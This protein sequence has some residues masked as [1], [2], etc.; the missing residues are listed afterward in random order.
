[1]PGRIV[2][3]TTPDGSATLVERGRIH[4]SGNWNFGSGGVNLAHVGIVNDTA[5]DVGL[6]VRMAAAQSARWMRVEDS[7]GNERFALTPTAL[8]SR[9][10]ATDNAW[11]AQ[12]DA[13]SFA[14]FVT[15][16]DGLL[17]WGGGAG[18][19]ETNL[20]REAA[21]I[22][23]TDDKLHVVGEIEVDGALNHDGTTVGFYAKVPVVQPTIVKLTDN[24]GGTGDDTIAAASML[25]D[26]SSENNFRADVARK[27]N[28]ILDAAGQ[29]AS[30]TGLWKHV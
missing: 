26:P 11:A 20:Y 14:R 15:R 17:E 5:T 29:A 23:A 16:A 7:G 21:N 4:N 8:I 24:S 22:L 27:I 1:M 28:E 2:F 9:A 30:G 12:V 10:A 13:D 25:Y 6:L 3:S 18:A 19:R